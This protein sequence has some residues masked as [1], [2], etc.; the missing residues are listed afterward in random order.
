MHVRWDGTVRWV[1]AHNIWSYNFFLCVEF[2]EILCPVDTLLIF[3]PPFK[4]RE[5]K[6]NAFSKLCSFVRWKSVI[7]KVFLDGY[8]MA[9][10]CVYYVYCF[11]HDH[12]WMNK[13]INS[14]DKRYCQHLL[15][16]RQMEQ[17]AKNVDDART[18]R[19]SVEKVTEVCAPAVRAH[20]P[21]QRLKHCQ[22]LWHTL[23]DLSTVVHTRRS[24]TF[25]RFK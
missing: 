15:F 7:E 8:I 19:L 3:R 20:S 14:A 16:N 21:E 1:N 6:K 13:K 9:L 24:S 4:E 22:V 25:S 23:I 11:I 18:G 10:K 5:E 12:G 17:F 2:H